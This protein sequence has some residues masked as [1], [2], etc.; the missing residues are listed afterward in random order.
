M[1]ASSAA[2]AGAE[3]RIVELAGHS[4]GKHR[5]SSSGLAGLDAAV[6]MALQCAAGRL[7]QAGARVPPPN[8]VVALVTFKRNRDSTRESSQAYGL[9]DHRQAQLFCSYSKAASSSPSSVPA[10]TA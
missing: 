9:Q 3:G 2:A 8:L 7:L 10:V 4:R 6:L 1:P 5:G